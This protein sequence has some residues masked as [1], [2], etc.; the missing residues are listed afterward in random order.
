M[1]IILKEIRNRLAKKRERFI[2]SRNLFW[3]TSGRKDLKKSEKKWNDICDLKLLCLVFYR[4]N[5]KAFV[6]WKIV[7]NNYTTTRRLNVLDT[8]SLRILRNSILFCMNSIPHSYQLRVL[9]YL[10]VSNKRDFQW[11]SDNPRRWDL[12]TNRA[13]VK[14]SSHIYTQIPSLVIIICNTRL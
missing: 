6:H 4:T 11:M 5:K 3:H 12:K 9:K 7:S 2:E 10:F 14:F 1:G 13:V 8:L